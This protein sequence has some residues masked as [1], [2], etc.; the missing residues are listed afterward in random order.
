VELI[1][2]APVGGGE[3]GGV[4]NPRSILG[5]DHREELRALLGDGVRFDE[6]MRRH[7]TLKLG[8]PADAFA[9]PRAAAEVGA[10]ARWCAARRL[11]LTVVG[12]GSNLLVRDGGV[13]GVVLGTGGLRGI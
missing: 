3:A 9:A 12:G 7:T 6:P 13:R 4:A 2:D 8:G 10:L 1:G 11:P 5:G